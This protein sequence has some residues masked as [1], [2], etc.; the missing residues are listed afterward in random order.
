MLHRCL[1]LTIGCAFASF[2]SLTLSQTPTQSGQAAYAAISEVVRILEAD[3]NT[4]WSKVN[5]EALRH[6]LI[7]MD[8]VTLSSSVVQRAIEGGL[9]MDV[10]GRARAVPAIRRLLTSHARSLDGSVYHL[11][12]TE[13]PN[14][15][16]LR[17]TARDPS[18][19][20]TVA[21]VRGLGFA[22]I[23]T[24]GNHHALHHIAVARGEDM[25][26]TH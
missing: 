2:P 15:T 8:Q 26:H 23:I 17:V 18:D 6:H 10:T 19:A 5:V 4:D 3:P 1:K 24:E 9:E 22:G 14:G 20:K 13:I 16:R 11:V 7:D 12:A 21:R 25:S